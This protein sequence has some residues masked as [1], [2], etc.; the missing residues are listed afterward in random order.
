[1]NEDFDFR[2][3]DYAAVFAE[4]ARRLSWLRDDPSVLSALKAF[5]RDNPAHFINDWGMT[6]DPR[7]IADGKPAIVPFILMP[8][9][10]EWIEWVVD[11]WLNSKP[12][13][14]EKS[15]DCGI[16]WLAV[17]LSCTLC[18][19]HDGLV[20][21]FGSRKEEYVD[22]L[23]SPKSLF[24]KAR[25]FMKYLPEEFTGGWDA[26]KHAPYM[27]LKFPAT[28]SY[29][30]GEAG[31]GIG[32][33]DRTGLY[34]V[35]ESAHLERPALIDASLS[36]TTNC[37]IDVSSVNG[38]A[39]PFAQKRMSG[40]IDVFRFHWIDD[41]RKDEAWYA[42]QCEELDPVTVAQEIDINY[43]ASAE[44]V[45]IPSLWV[46][47]A[48]DAHVKLGVE[49]TGSI[50]GA[51]DI[52]DEGVDKNAFAVGKGILLTHIEEW[53]GKDSDT[54]ATVQRA[55][56]L[57]Q[58]YECTLLRY[59]SDGMGALVRGDI[60]VINEQRAERKLKPVQVVPFRGSDGV[61]RP[62]AQDVRGRLN[63]DYFMN[64]KAQAWFHLRKLFRNTY[65]A[66]IEGAEFDPAEIISLSSAL[67]LLGKLQMELSQPTYSMNTIGKIVVDKAPDGV[68]SPNL[69][70]AVMMRYAP[71][72]RPMVISDEAL[73]PKRPMRIR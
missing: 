28:D 66:V 14:T 48:I 64:R 50:E 36:A 60:R 32:R 44:G 46:N 21:G 15:R 6:F 63:K 13:L 30:T 70:D 34:I 45:L 5:Y 53:S 17:A 43:N 67:P 2:N 8:K 12:G 23:D 71:I 7:L 56:E 69:A 40:K 31:D 61:Y 19:F 62:E 41:P 27:R 16:S 57:Y 58:D 29:M 10:H 59:D 3:P 49:P 9:Q 55:G 20:V 54:F 24:F 51:L 68:K 42:K 72:I 4:R 65:R 37:R 38:S 33:G 47:A 11:H 18:L 1:M 26:K 22:K 73:A 39:N 35:D 25:M 52:A